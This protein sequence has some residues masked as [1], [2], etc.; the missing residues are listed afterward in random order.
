MIKKRSFAATVLAI[1]MAFSAIGA[2]LASNNGPPGPG[3][4]HNGKCIGNPAYRL[5]GC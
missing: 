4:S 5:G 1:V 3:N 2:T